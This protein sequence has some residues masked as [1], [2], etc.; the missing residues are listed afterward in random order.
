MVDISGNMPHVPGDSVSCPE[1]GRARAGAAQD[2]PHRHCTVGGR[3]E[4]Y[5][6]GSLL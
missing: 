5:F 3:E 4:Y 6:G 2:P 1:Q